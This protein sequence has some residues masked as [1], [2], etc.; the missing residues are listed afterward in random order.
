MKDASEI[1]SMP[2][3]T[4]FDYKKLFYAVIRR[5]WI[6]AII[7]VSVTTAVFIYTLNEVPLYRATTQ[8]LIE[9]PQTSGVVSKEVRATSTTGTDYYPTQYEI[10]KSIIL[11]KRVV[12]AL[13]LASLP[14]FKGGRPE[15]VLQKMVV[16]EPVKKSRLVDVS[17]DSPKP[18]LAAKIA[19]TLAD[20]YIKQNAETT[21]FMSKDLLKTL[22]EESAPGSVESPSTAADREKIIEMLPSVVSDPTL[23]GFRT[24]RSKL[25]AEIADLSKRYKAKHPKMISLN[26]RLESINEQIR[27]RTTIVVENVKSDLAGKLRANNIMVVFKAEVPQHPMR[28]KKLL[29][30]L[31]AVVLSLAFSVGLIHFLETLDKTV[32]NQEDVQRYLRVPLLGNFPFLKGMAKV[33]ARKISQLDE[34]D[35][36]MVASSAIREIRTSLTFSV[37]QKMAKIITFTSTVPKEGKSF[38]AAYLAHSFAK[39]G[40]KT[41]LIDGDLRLPVAHLFFGV[42][43]VPGLGNILSEKAS[44]NEAIVETDLQNLFILP[45]GESHADPTELFGSPA[46]GRVIEGLSQLFDKIIIDAPPALLIPDALVLSKI[47][48]AM[49]LVVRSGQI[50]LKS[51]LAVKEKFDSIDS[52][53]MGF[54]LNGLDIEQDPYYKNHYKNYY[55]SADA[56][57]RRREA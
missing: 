20:L 51:L 12:G 3:E 18:E 57:K 11:M 25:T 43:S 30:L 36:N 7:T 8:L 1:N 40:V 47:S 27:A 50:E 45:S 28:S 22:S 33:G 24:E 16:V 44:L 23:Q 31:V 41:L 42:N 48:D 34:I 17:V 35:K 52:S 5:F 15:E 46:M 14:E 53:I 38:I 37:K 2:V 26:T 49:I 4:E 55:H 29:Y 56:S 19:N 39:N 54:I 21:L 6:V 13:G 9:A 32:K 10:I